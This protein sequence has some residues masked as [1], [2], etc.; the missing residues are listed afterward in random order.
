MAMR[1]EKLTLDD[2]RAL[3]DALANAVPLRIADL[4]RHGGPAD[5]DFLRAS[6]IC[7]ALGEHGD[8]LLFPSAKRGETAKMFND[9][10]QAL[11][12][13]AFVPGGVHAFGFV[14]SASSVSLR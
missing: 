8:A 9:F 1:A 6:A 4:R 11:A 5:E 14:F 7:T 12:V 3:A 10:S 2:V 13:M